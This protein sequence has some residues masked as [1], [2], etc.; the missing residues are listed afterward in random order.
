MQRNG[1][2]LW[3]HLHGRAAGKIGIWKHVLKQVKQKS[4][5]Q[6][7]LKQYD[8]SKVPSPS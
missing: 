8:E 1:A 5:Y 4:V 6:L 7:P 2:K 3:H